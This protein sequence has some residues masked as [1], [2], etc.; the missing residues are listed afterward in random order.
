MFILLLSHSLFHVVWTSHGSKGNQNTWDPNEP[1]NVDQSRSDLQCHSVP[2]SEYGKL[3]LPG[4][5]KI[6]TQW[7]FRKNKTNTNLTNWANLNNTINSLVSIDSLLI[8]NCK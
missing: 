7:S 5:L 1:I 2:I 8:V 6:N 4:Q 3:M